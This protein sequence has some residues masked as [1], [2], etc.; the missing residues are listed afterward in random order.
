MT[1]EPKTFEQ[2]EAD[3]AAR[4]AAIGRTR[5]QK[6]LDLAEQIAN[7]PDVINA[8]PLGTLWSHP[9][10]VCPCGSFSFI[11]QRYACVNG[12]KDKCELK[13]QRCAHVGTWDWPTMR[14]IEG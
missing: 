7:S 3:A 14:F 4:W 5:A 12:I 2:L 13:C 10:I 6:A 8:P 9:A 11:V 1:D